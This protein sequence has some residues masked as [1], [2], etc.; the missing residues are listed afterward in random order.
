MQLIIESGADLV[1]LTLLQFRDQTCLH[2]LKLCLARQPMPI[3][4]HDDVRLID[5]Q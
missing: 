4:A 5:L 1:G 2:V 3:Q